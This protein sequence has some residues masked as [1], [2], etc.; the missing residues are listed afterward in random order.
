MCGIIGYISNRNSINKNLYEQKF[1]K[2]FNNQKYRGPDFKKNISIDSYSEKIVLGFNRLSITDLTNESNKIFFDNNFYLLFNGEIYNSEK[3]KN[4]YFSDHKFNTTA[5]TE[6]LFKFLSKFGV[7]KIHELEGMFSIVFINLNLSKIYLIRDYTGVK[8]LYYL[9]NNEGIF[10]SSE[11][12][13]CYSLSSKKIN[14]KSF[15]YFLNFGFSP[16][17]E[18]LIED[19]KKVQ[20]CT[21]IEYNFLTKKINFKKY[22][23]I[24]KKNSIKSCTKENLNN[25]LETVISKNLFTKTKIGLFL[26]GGLDSTILAFLMKKYSKDYEA[27]TSVFLPQNEYQK[28]NID[29][30]FAKKVSKILNIKL[31]ISFIDIRN[32][33]QKQL[34]YDSLNFLDEPISNFNFISSYM[35]SSLAKQNNCK[36]ILTGDGSDEIFG[37]YKRYRIIY[38]ARKLNLLSF[39]NKKIKKINSLTSNNLPFFFYE[40]FNIKNY[41]YLFD[42]DFYSIINNDKNYFYFEFKNKYLEDNINDFDFC[43]WLAEESNLKLDRSTMANSIEARVPFQDIKLIK[44]IYPIQNQYK[45]NFFEQKILLK[46]N[47]DYIPSFIK[48]RKKNGW[49][50]PES[51]F[52][53]EFFEEMFNSY[54]EKNKIKAQKIFNYENIMSFYNLHKTKKKYL[55]N[56]ICT[57][58]SFQVWYDK[59]LSS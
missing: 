4:H 42:K 11:A 2:Y 14:T 32:T 59:M 19:V 10:F 7:T 22:F 45:V 40:K 57:I 23:E 39:F 21:I 27:Y 31:N 25:L 44:E 56:E 3:L 55:K 33:A 58:L 51:I 18:T 30:D 38:L 53:R 1:N 15:N 28:F 37:G 29:L 43:Y 13:F 9:L 41:N 17:N 46:K 26:S 6:L 52:L 35:Q 36:V 8:P 47:L 48:N 49:F 20:P 54:F 34:I 24:P 16:I 12:W 50:F 5:D